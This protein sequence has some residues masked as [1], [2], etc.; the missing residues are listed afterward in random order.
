LLPGGVS[1][2]RG[3]WGGSSFAGGGG[4]GGP[5]Q[6]WSYTQWAPREPSGGG[7]RCGE[8]FDDGASSGWNDYLCDQVW[9]TDG[10]VCEFG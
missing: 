6:A 10:F 3:P 5:G 9:V 1:L 4:G 2:S 8:A 7:E